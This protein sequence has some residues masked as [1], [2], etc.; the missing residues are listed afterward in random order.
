MPILSLYKL[1]HHKSHIIDIRKTQNCANYKIP[2]ISFQI[3]ALN[4]SLDQNV[5]CEYVHM[6]GL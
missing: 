2:Q 4:I 1:P 6:E 5:I 3:H